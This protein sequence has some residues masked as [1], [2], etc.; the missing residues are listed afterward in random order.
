ME[1]Y[2]KTVRYFMEEMTQ[3]EF[4]ALVREKSTPLKPFQFNMIRALLPVEDHS[5]VTEPKIA[6]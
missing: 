5:I 1:D 6:E 2:Q 4:D 3:E